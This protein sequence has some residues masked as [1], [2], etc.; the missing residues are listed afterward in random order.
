[1]R[2]SRC[3]K[4]VLLL[5]VALTAQ[6]LFA[7]TQTGAPATYVG[8]AAC[9]RCH[10]D[11]VHRYAATPMARTSGAVN[12]EIDQAAFTHA[13]SAIRYR[14]QRS[15]TGAV[16]H[17]AGA[18]F[19]GQQPLHYFIGSNVA[20]RS[21][22]FSLDRYLFEAPV[23]YYAQA[24]RW[25]V[26]PG[27]EADRALRMNRPIDANCLFCHASQSQPIYSTENRFAEPPFKQDGVSC[28]RCHGPASLHIEGKAHLVNPAKLD[29]SRRDA[30]CQQ[31][32][33]AGA[34]RVEL[35]GQ[36]LAR[37]RPGE[38]LAERV[39]FFVYES[40]ARSG[41]KVNSHVENLAA[42]QCQQKSGAAMSCLSCH[43]P[44]DAPKPAE[45][46][47]YYRNR[48]LQCHQSERL[49]ATHNRNADC[50]SC[51]MPRQR[52]TD[53]GHGV[54]TDHAIPRQAIA[55][56]QHIA[57][58]APTTRR[59][60]PFAGFTSDERSLGLAYAEVALTE[61]DAW[62]AAEALRLLTI[63][64]AQYPR[65]A[66][67]LTQLGFL[68]AQRGDTARAMR[69]YELAISLEPQRTVSLINLGGIYAAQGRTEEAIKLWRAALTRNAG[70]TE[71][72]LN[73]A[74]AYLAQEKS[75]QAR[76]V[77]Q[78]ALRF[79]PGSNDVRTLLRR[80]EAVR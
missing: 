48:C 34:A 74:R 47:D 35:P 50:T 11:I 45:R 21:F 70:L 58:V 80:T 46:A 66:E 63:A 60:R 42:S 25:D 3:C 7:Q 61:N 65:D 17:Y 29:A 71:A 72:A 76:E 9:V 55:T 31:C 77:L 38:A 5:I 54:M 30:I 20:G 40:A 33:L 64:L 67:L 57:T 51:H 23:T 16:L 4:L 28:E 26:S 69:A 13:P 10:A 22:L 75:A 1:M 12:A 68:H 44:H 73:L 53:G 36:S 41:L 49:P 15:A 78:Q 24:K 62:A 18:G 14:M 52:A 39:T 56:R 2:F 37:F 8:N 6:W 79:D 32:H 59:L 19:S 27:Y 43:D